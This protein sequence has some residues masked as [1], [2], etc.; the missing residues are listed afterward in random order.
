[1]K[2]IPNGRS[3]YCKTTRT[4]AHYVDTNDRQHILFLLGVTTKVCCNS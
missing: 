3:S 4:K 2:G 1:V